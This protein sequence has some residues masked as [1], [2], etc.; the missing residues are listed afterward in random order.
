MPASPKKKNTGSVKKIPI[1]K[2]TP[3]KGP[4]KK[5][6]AKK[7]VTKKSVSKKPALK[8]TSRKKVSSANQDILLKMY[9]VRLTQCF[10]TEVLPLLQG[11]QLPESEIPGELLPLCSVSEST[12]YRGALSKTVF[13]RPGHEDCM[14]ALDLVKQDLRLAL[15]DVGSPHGF[16]V[17]GHKTLSE[18]IPHPSV[19]ISLQKSS[20]DSESLKDFVTF[21]QEVLLSSAKAHRVES[22]DKVE[23]VKKLPREESPVKSAWEFADR[24][25][26][27]PLEVVAI[28]DKMLRVAL[29]LTDSQRENLLNT[30]PVTNLTGGARLVTAKE[31][32]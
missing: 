1:K 6:T 8:V 29:V 22:V 2:A 24:R 26:V 3:A 7:A 32:M 19:S 25:K 20:K 13:I 10:A 12:E 27:A 21:V 4:L 30:P 9:L 31:L 28:G 23:I 15:R 16:Y 18:E 5:V 11:S 14:A 17:D